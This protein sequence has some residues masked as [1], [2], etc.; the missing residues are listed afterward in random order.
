MVKNLP[1]NPGDTGSIP[2]GGTQIPHAMGQ[3]SLYTSTREKPVH[4][5]AEPM[6]HSKKI[7]CGT[8]KTSGARNKQ[9]NIDQIKK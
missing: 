2:G 8:T 1:S 4:P 7:P 3:L 6:C 9:V 5:K